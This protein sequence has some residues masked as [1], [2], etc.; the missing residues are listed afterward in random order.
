MSRA[1]E[2]ERIPEEYKLS[3]IYSIHKKGENLNCQ[4]YRGISLLCT[5]YKIFTT[6][7]YNKLEPYAEKVIQ[8]Y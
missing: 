7:L 3:I 2:K 8:E 5:A 1:W 4:N 6:L